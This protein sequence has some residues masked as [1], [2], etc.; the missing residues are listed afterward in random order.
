[1]MI[2]AFGRLVAIALIGAL[3]ACTTPPKLSA[4]GATVQIVEREPS[5]TCSYLD[6]LSGYVLRYTNSVDVLN[7][8]GAAFGAY[9]TSLKNKV[10]EMGGNT[11]VLLARRDDAAIFYDVYS[12][13]HCV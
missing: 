4:Q 8:R 11:A 9:Q 7:A 5:G 3:S 2:Q 10:A 6:E 13:Y 1:M 12:V